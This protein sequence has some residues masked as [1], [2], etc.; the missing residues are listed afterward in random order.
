MRANRIVTG[1]VLMV[2]AFLFAASTTAVAQ[3]EKTPSQTYMEYHAALQKAKKIEDILPFMSAAKRKEAASMPADMKSGMI[4][5]IQELG[6]QPGFKV[7]KEDKTATGATLMLEGVDK[8]KSKTSV[9][10]TMVREAGAWKIEKEDQ[11]T[12]K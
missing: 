1:S 5:M 10:V 9:T 6:I 3:T 12:G 2:V 11:K 7:V 8:S 4:G